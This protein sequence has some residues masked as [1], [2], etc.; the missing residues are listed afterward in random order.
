MDITPAYF[1]TERSAFFPRLVARLDWS[2]LSSVLILSILGVLF[3]YSAMAQGGHGRAFVLRQSAAL[4]IGFSG[5]VFLTALPYQ[6]FQT[7]SKGIYVA[8]VVL[9]VAVL[10]FGVKLRGSRAW[11]N[12]HLFYLQPV[13]IVRLAL[14]VALAAYVDAKGREVRSWGG[15]VAPFSLMGLYLALILAQPDLSSAMALGPM[16]LAVLYVAG[17]PTT[18][19]VAVAAAG[20]IALGIP[21][22]STYLTLSGPGK[23][24][25]TFIRQ[26]FLTRAGA[27][28]FW[29]AVCLAVAAGWWFLRRWRV[30]IPSV[31]LAGTLAVILSGVAGSFVVEK[32]LKPYQRKRLVAFLNPAL[33]PLGAGYNIRQSEIAI[34]SGRFFGKGYLSGSQ[35]QL[36]FLP[37][38][39]TDFVFSLVAEELGFLG[40]L[41]VLAIY[42]WIVWRAFDIASSARDGF[43]RF[44]A[45][46]L[47]T[48]F[49]FTGLVNIGMVMGLMPV[50]G[51]PL[52]FL[53]YGG[54]GLVGSFLAV[55]LLL[56]IHWRRYIL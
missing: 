15:I 41:S 24:A 2:L 31:Y 30:F 17:V 35:T 25:D 20:A 1:K 44:L 4:F 23:G 46:G 3:I 27:W 8:G 13:E 19:L 37:E 11:F 33:D 10:L 49:G 43:G 29:G 12:F 47:G 34:G 18:A 28:Q 45:V 32:A 14:A 51:L 9:L 26:A 42:F 16:T 22:T 40:A 39:H 5:L 38:K 7:Y 36:G 21:L 55:G 48:Y 6:I 52:P 50:T 53:S 56:S 54:S